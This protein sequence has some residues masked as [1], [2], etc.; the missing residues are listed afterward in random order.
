MTLRLYGAALIQFQFRE[1]NMG[2]GQRQLL[3]GA[4]VGSV[5]LYLF[6][7]FA[8]CFYP[9][10]EFVGLRAADDKQDR[11]KDCSKGYETFP[12]RHISAPLHDSLQSQ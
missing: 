4:I 12:F 8:G 5:L 10:L 2:L 11:Q 6:E 7:L 3:R 9:A 1:A